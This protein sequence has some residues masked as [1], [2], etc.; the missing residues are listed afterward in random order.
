MKKLL[1]WMIT[2]LIITIIITI[3]IH[4]NTPEFNNQLC[5]T[6]IIFLICLVVHKNVFESVLEI[7]YDLC[8]KS[9]IKES[10]TT[11]TLDFKL[12]G[13]DF[14]FIR[15]DNYLINKGKDSDVL[16]TGWNISHLLL[17]MIVGFLCPKLTILWLFIGILWEFLET[18]K[19]V[20]CY[21]YTDM[22]YNITGLYIGIF[23][24]HKYFN[25]MYSIL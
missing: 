3:K 15:G 24:H 22:F 13:Y 21:D 9:D 6:F 23:L 17:Y 25:K 2:F 20:D 18:F 7:D 10:S 1:L 5:I 12:K 8:K 14:S 19:E 16:I 4:D 11:S